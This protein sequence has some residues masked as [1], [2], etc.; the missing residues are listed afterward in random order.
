MNEHQKRLWQHMI[1]VIENYLDKNNENFHDVV[2]ELEGALD[3]SEI[4]N[5]EL[6]SEWYD[7][8]TPLEVWRATDSQ[9]DDKEGVIDALQRMKTFLKKNIYKK[10]ILE[11]PEYSSVNDIRLNWEQDFMVE[12]TQKDGVVIIR[13]NNGGL[14]SM[15][16]H[17]LNLAQDRVPSG[18]HLHFDTSNSL[19]KGSLELIVQKE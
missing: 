13:A 12:V 5:S 10:V 2:G 17:F 3:A 11:V 19:N 7:Y 6:I 16:N 8:W 4:K 18:Y 14:T 15:A 9:D 1:D